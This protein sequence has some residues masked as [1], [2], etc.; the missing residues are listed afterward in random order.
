LKP[1][2]AVGAAK[3]LA[4][5]L[6]RL[7]VAAEH[8]AFITAP[9]QHGRRRSGTG[10][11][12]WQ[13][14]ALRDGDDPRRIDWRRSAQGD[15]YFLREREHE[16]QTIFML[17]LHDTPGLAFQ[18]SV[19]LPSKQDRAVLVLLALAALLLRAGERVALA[20]ITPPLR[21]DH[22]LS[23]LAQSMVTGGTAPV[24]PRARRVAF[25]DFLAPAP[26]FE[27]PPGGA[28]VQILDPAE[29]DFPYTGRVRFAGFA[30]EIEREAGE[31]GAWR[32]TYLN[33]LAAQRE[34]VV[35]AATRTG[36]TPLFHRT[37]AAPAIVLSAL[38]QALRKL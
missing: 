20:G 8:L 29:C 17:Q 25:G 15:R 21:G 19:N 13:F 37:D 32:T 11:S 38:F 3:A 2:A 9:G 33:R 34:A 31:V 18:S 36:Q 1:A 35:K 7:L 12:F 24:D 26:V 5:G 10:D 28:V 14:R 22:A 6:P 27:G 30:G 4:A 16:A 23:Q